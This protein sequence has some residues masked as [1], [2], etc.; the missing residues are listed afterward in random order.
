MKSS[1]I[2]QE[3]SQAG[4]DSIF[5]SRVTVFVHFQYDMYVM[6]LP[7]NYLTHT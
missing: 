2:K 5:T 7:S 4:D 3:M 1:L 6:A